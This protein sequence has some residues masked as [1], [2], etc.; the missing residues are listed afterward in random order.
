VNFTDQYGWLDLINRYW[1]DGY[2]GN[3]SPASPWG[4]GPWFLSTLWYGLYYAERADYTANNGDIDNHKYRIEL[5]IEELG[6]VGFGA[7]Q[8]APYCNPCTCP[9]CGSLL[10]PGETDFVLQTAWPNAWESMS[11]FVDA[12]MAFLDYQPDA[13]ASGFRIEPKLPTA[14]DTMTYRNLYVGG[15]RFDVR[16]DEAPGRNSNTFTNVT[17]GTLNYDTFIRVPAGSNVFAVTQDCATRP[18]TYDA[19]TGRVQVSG[20]LNSGAASE[21]VVRVYYGLRGD[22]DVNLAVD[23]ADLPALV[24]VLLGADSDCTKLPI[25]DMNGDGAANALDIQMFVDAA[26][27]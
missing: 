16:C 26:I 17:G 7:E 12:L 24:V 5:C 14:W 10:Y 18:I 4:A 11:T 27:P 22:F 9:D 2:W 8:I 21:T 13:A 1:G 3:G 23:L 20:A 15:K 25:A 19:G 6:P